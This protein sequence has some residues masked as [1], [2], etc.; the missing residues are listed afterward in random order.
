MIHELIHVGGELSFSMSIPGDK[1]L[2]LKGVKP[3]NP[4]AYV[5]TNTG[6]FSVYRLNHTIKSQNTYN[7]FLKNITLITLYF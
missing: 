5:K 1:Y 3:I 4:F 2:K 6:I 7:T